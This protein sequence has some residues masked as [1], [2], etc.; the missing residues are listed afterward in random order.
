M[1]SSHKRLYVL[2]A[3]AILVCALGVGAALQRLRLLGG[4]A[5]T[6]IARLLADATGAQASVQA[7]ELDFAN[8]TLVAHGV[9]LHDRGR[10][11]LSAGELRARPALNALLRGR[12]ELRSLEL[13]AGA[14]HV[15]AGDL[16][17]LKR[18]ALRPRAQLG[19][20]DLR[21]SQLR[22]DLGAGTALQLSQ[23]HLTL[24]GSRFELHAAKAQLLRDAT[25]LADARLDA[26]GQISAAQAVLHGAGQLQL[27]T[28]QL[29]GNALAEPLT[30]SWQIDGERVQCDGALALGAGAGSLALSLTFAPSSPLTLRLRPTATKLERALALVQSSLPVDALID[31]ELELHGTLHPLE[32]AGPMQLALREL[33]V[34]HATAVLAVPRLRAAGRA[35][36]DASGFALDALRISLPSGTFEGSARASSA[37]ELTA[38]LSA[39]E[40]ALRDLGPVAGVTLAG[41]GRVGLQA[42]GPLQAP[43]LHLALALEDAALG[44]VE[45]GTLHAELDVTDA[46]RALAIQHAELSGSQRRLSADGVQL[47]FAAGLDEAHAHIK[48]TRLPLA[49]LYRVLGAAEDPVLRRLQGD[50]AGD[51]ELNYRRADSDHQLELALGLRVTDI[52]LAGYRFERGQLRAHVAIPDGARGLGGGEL[53]LD[54]M[55]LAAGDG[56]LEL[57]GG[58]RH[59]ALAMHI[60]M[61]ALPLARDTWFH[62]HWA[63]LSGRIDG[64]GDL[65]GDASSTRADLALTVNELKFSDSALGSIQLRALL[66]DRAGAAQLSAADGACSEGKAA[67]ASAAFSSGWLICGDGLHDRLH[68]DL[69]L[70]NADGRALRGRLALDDFSL[71]S[72]LPETPSGAH[73]PGTLSTRLQLTGGG[74]DNLDRLSGNLLVQKLALGEGEMSLSSTAPFEVQLDAGS[75]AMTRA[76]LRGAKQKFLL[77]TTGALGHSARLIA[78]GSVS[79]SAFSRASEPLVEAFGDVG[80]HLEWSPWTQPRLSGRASLDAVTIRIGAETFLR[81]LTGALEISDARVHVAGVGAELGGGR[82]QLDGQ[83]ERQGF[84]VADYALSLTAAG[85]ALEPQP[86]VELLLDADTHIDWAGGSALPRLSGGVMLKRALY[87]KQIQ[88]SEAIAALSHQSAEAAGA[89]RATRDRLQID[90]TVSHEKPLRIRNSFLDGEVIVLGPEHKLRIVGSDRQLGL[91]GQL[92]ITRGRVLFY[93]DEFHVTHGEIAFTDPSRIAPQFD[94]SAVADQPKRPDTSVVFHAHGTRETFDVN[95]HCEAP[96]S[97]EPPPF[98]C[99]YAHDHVR[100]DNYEQLVALWLCR[101]KPTLS[102]ADPAH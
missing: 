70:G 51:A 69:A 76:P 85:V 90:L 91:S 52:E 23:A 5:R 55:T 96:G 66:R 53:R 8:W 40:L 45:L 25:P 81:N 26:T 39:A 2:T 41:H 63:A 10:E 58:M 36:L 47:R 101:T 14:I 84:S 99:K 61:H 98:T 30:L 16:A 49:E 92:A 43:A 86:H 62:E 57:S 60:A 95:V 35:R 44:G 87:G 93:G 100:C 48:L 42:R 50:A 59:G 6:E 31:G 17:R 28:A 21:S 74:L 77:S 24:A 88:M 78:D 34:G 1:G 20:L 29:A 71:A 37:A 97:G 89:K 11:L 102:Q 12:L 64:K 75:L 22:V 65:N 13:S 67:L 56:A 73:V 9:A 46:G 80:L 7:T 15:D 38:E 27:A 4:N 94:I 19:A 33:R 68:V 18:A 79:A 3:A 54:Q 82:L 83:L 32:L 72:F